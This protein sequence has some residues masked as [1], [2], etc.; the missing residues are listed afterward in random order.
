[1]AHG[2]QIGRLECRFSDPKGWTKN[3]NKQGIIQSIDLFACA[4]RLRHSQTLLVLSLHLMQHLP[5]AIFVDIGQNVSLICRS[6][7]S[8]TTTAT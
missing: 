5:E 1:V 6:F 4:S 3:K 8:T 2:L 7:Q